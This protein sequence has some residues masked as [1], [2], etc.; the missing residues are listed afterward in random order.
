MQIIKLK[1][2]IT[3]TILYSFGL[4]FLALWWAD[5]VLVLVSASRFDVRRA[6]AAELQIINREMMAEDAGIHLSPSHYVPVAAWAK[7]SQAY[8]ENIHNSS[9]RGLYC[10]LGWIRR[11][12][13]NSNAVFRVVGLLGNLLDIKKDECRSSHADFIS[14]LCF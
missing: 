1:I 13:H 7:N 12:L 10:S 3:H 14:H 5:E 9:R 2:I 8:I 11:G 4:L 6:P